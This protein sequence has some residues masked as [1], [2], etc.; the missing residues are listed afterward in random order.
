MDVVRL[1]RHPRNQNVGY[2]SDDRCYIINVVGKARRVRGIHRLL[3]THL[4]PEYDY[5]KTAAAARPLKRQRKSAVGKPWNQRNR[6]MGQRMLQGQA[7]GTAVHQQLCD[8]ARYY[9]VDPK[10]FTKKHPVVH[11]YT[12]KVLMAL[13]RWGL[14]LWYGEW[15][16]YDDHIGYATAVDMLCT[17]R[18]GSVVL[19][20]VKTGYNG[21]FELG[22]K[23]MAGPMGKLM[24]DSP[25]NQAMLQALVM[26]QT[27]RKRYGSLSVQAVVIHVS[28]EGVSLHSPRKKLD[29]CAGGLYEWLASQEKIRKS[30]PRRRKV[31]QRTIYSSTTGKG[32]RKR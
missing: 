23:P 10:K 31:Y 3:S 30:Q 1:M 12:T 9:Q 20:E 26:E 24:S 6:Y 14:T 11:P 8:Y 13:R 21:S 2:S 5:K 28:D 15:E 18:K 29:H 27:V 17:D 25:A 19:V 7:R 16:I 22:H 4:W 32:S